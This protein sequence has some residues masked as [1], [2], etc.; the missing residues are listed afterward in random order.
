MSYFFL[1][2]IQAEKVVAVTIVG[3]GNDK[4]QWNGYSE[5]EV[6]ESE[7]STEQ[8]PFIEGVIVDSTSEVSVDMEL[9]FPGGRKGFNVVNMCVR[10]TQARRTALLAVFLRTIHEERVPKS[11]ND[12]VKYLWTSRP[13][14]PLVVTVSLGEA[15]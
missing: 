14:S 7:G 2:R 3:N 8:V 13:Y 10:G 4:N 11:R 12:L 6:C 5:V 9:S 15:E 1:G